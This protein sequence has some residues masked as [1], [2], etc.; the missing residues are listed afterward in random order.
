[1]TDLVNRATVLLLRQS[2]APTAVPDFL[3]LGSGPGLGIGGG[4]GAGMG[5]LFPSVT[6]IGSRGF[7]SPIFALRSMGT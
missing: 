7:V 6:P 2:T 1:M 4:V 5:G 3:V